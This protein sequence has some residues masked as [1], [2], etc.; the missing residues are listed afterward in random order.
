MPII[1][2]PTNVPYT[3][4]VGKTYSYEYPLGL[5][6]KPGSQLHADLVARITS[7]ARDARAQISGRYTNWRK[8]DKTLTAYVT[9][10][11]AFNQNLGDNEELQIVVPMSCAVM[12][13][14][15]AHVLTGYLNGP[16]FQ[17]RGAG[18][19]DKVKAMLLELAIDAQCQRFKTILPIHTQLRD[20]IAYGLGIVHPRWETV[21]GRKIE[22]EEETL[23][24]QVLGTVLGIRRKRR[25][26][27]R[28]PVS[29][30]NALDVWD[31]YNY[32]P[33]PNVAPGNVQAS[34][35]VGCI[36]PTNYYA[37][38]SMEQDD[39]ETYF[40]VRYLENM[41]FRI[42]EK[43]T[44]GWTSMNRITNDEQIIY[45]KRG[46][47]LTFY[48]TLVP[49]E[50]K[51]GKS[52]Y[53]EKWVFEI[54][55]D[56][57]LIRANP[58]NF[59]HD[60]YPVGVAAPTDD[61]HTLAPISILETIYPMQSLLDWLAKSHAHNVRKALNNMLI[62]DPSIINYADVVNPKPGKIIRIREHLWGRGVKDAVEQLA[63][64][65]VT[66]THLQDMGTTID[67]LQRVS[68]AV[69]TLQG[70]VRTGGERR[71]ATEMRD[72]RMSA[73]SRIQ[74]Q[75]Y[76][77]SVQSLRDV[78]TMFAT[79][80][81][82][83]MENNIYLDLVGRH[84]SELEAIYQTGSLDANPLDFICDFD[85]TVAD[86]MTEGGE[87]LNESVQIFQLIQSNPQT[88]QA[89]DMVRM[90]LDLMRKSGMKDPTNFLL[91]QYKVLPDEEAVNMAEDQGMVP[92]SSLLPEELA[93]V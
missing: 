83:F 80:L 51:V 69:D 24:S 15:L 64:T 16:L 85:L 27:K 49:R 19:E 46:D 1:Q 9:E 22:V 35:F 50:W 25:M 61:G 87:Y 6:L 91:P 4:E 67:M 56:A 72:T 63:I 10:E 30:G 29:E 32:L 36:R 78:G 11:A 5:D 68:G 59:V 42:S 54:A 7:M 18:P 75:A 37:L 71:S 65:D 38:L 21:Y 40:N 26:S 70:I 58:L 76:L 45:G 73:L 79:N 33:D 23:L 17:Y 86:G 28:Q 41:D 53:P 57:V 92:T 84:R 47:V 77:M 31:P 48:C 66:R 34:Q 3:I 81:Q 93:N 12:D 20:A 74:K 62:V 82:Q 55:G 52:Q 88:V 2:N 89:F 13:T 43:E 14:I 39:P 90:S 8:I 44:S 60:K